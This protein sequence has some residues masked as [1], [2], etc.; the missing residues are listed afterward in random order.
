MDFKVVQ[1]YR[2]ICSEGIFFPN[3][4]IHIKNKCFDFLKGSYSLNYRPNS[5][6]FFL[7]FFMF[8]DPIQVPTLH[9]VVCLLSLLQLK[10]VLSL[11]LSFMT[12]THLTNNGEVF[13]RISL[14][15]VFAFWGRR[16]RNVTEYQDIKLYLSQ[17]ISGSTNYKQ[18]Y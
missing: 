4:N 10:T 17:L 14:N 11:S 2:K 15:L 5:P 18:V 3:F 7:T 12:F 13:H 1:Y 16:V 8:Q 6:D 9:L